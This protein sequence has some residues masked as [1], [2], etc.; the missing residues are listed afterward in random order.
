MPK[1]VVDY[2]GISNRYLN[3]IWNEDNPFA[4][5]SKYYSELADK[6]QTTNKSD[7]VEYLEQSVI[8]DKYNLNQITLLVSSYDDER[9]YQEIVKIGDFIFKQIDLEAVLSSTVQDADKTIRNTKSLV[10]FIT[11]GCY[12]TDDRLGF[13]QAE[14]FLK[15]NF[16]QD[17]RVVQWLN[18]YQF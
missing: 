17:T 3:V 4:S 12:L 15:E 7:Y 10:M 9:R 11:K 13:K 6:T 18:Y 14:K 8:Y 16:G 2:F 1:R 5:I